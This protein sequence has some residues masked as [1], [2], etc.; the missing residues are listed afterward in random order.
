VSVRYV[1][2]LLAADGDQHLVPREGKV[3][4]RVNVSSQRFDTPS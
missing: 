4:Q 3:A 1:Y 2:P